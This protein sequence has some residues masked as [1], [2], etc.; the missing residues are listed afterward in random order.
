MDVDPGYIYIEEI[1]GG[2][3]WFMMESKDFNSKYS[4]V[5]KMK[6]EDEHLLV[7]NQSLSVYQSEKFN[8]YYK[9]LPQTLI[10]SRL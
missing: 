9:I 10:K 2:I 7:P 1:R 8:F 4:L 6:I 3:P 5:L